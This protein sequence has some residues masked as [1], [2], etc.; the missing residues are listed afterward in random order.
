MYDNLKLFAKKLNASFKI[1]VLLPH[2]YDK[3]NKGYKAL[4]IVSN[5]NPFSDYKLNLENIINQK[6]MIGIAI[7]PSLDVKKNQLL[8]NIFDDTYNFS[9]LYQAFII[10]EVMPLLKEKYRLNSD[11]EGNYILG[12]KD[13]SLLAYGLAYHY[14]TF[15]KLYLFDFDIKA[16]KHFLADLMSS[17]DPSIGFYL[18]A[19]DA[20]LAKE[21]KERLTMFG[22]I[23]YHELDSILSLET[24]L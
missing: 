18:N 3:T 2:D 24:V 1:T 17:F 12:Y 13:T 9:N 4:Y 6:N 8:Y 5:S 16:K 11:K 23:E 7:Y 22:I 19:K 14:D 15:E 21:I 10:K 20:L